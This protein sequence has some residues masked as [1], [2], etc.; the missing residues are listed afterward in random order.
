MV[1]CACSIEPP[2]TSP[3]NKATLRTIAEGAA[4]EV[5]VE[6]FPS[7]VN[8]LATA[9]NVDY[10]YI[11]ELGDDG[12]TFRSRAA[13]GKGEPLSPFDVPAQGP[14]ETVLKRNCVHH[15]SKLQELYPDVQLIQD[16]GVESYCGVPLVSSSGLVL[17]HLAVMD[18][19]PMPDEQLVSWVLDIFAS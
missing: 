18:S 16:I 17:G 1:R 6:F 4:R 14:C 13:W 10:A 8:N 15:P 12:Q 3:K 19:D 5:G 11:S 7:L 2:A 9:L